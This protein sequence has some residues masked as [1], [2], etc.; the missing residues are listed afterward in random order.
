MLRVEAVNGGYGGVRVLSGVDLQVAAG[1]VLGVL[2]RN[3]AGK[4][5]LLKTI[6]GLLPA[7]GGQ[8]LI[9][10]A[11]ATRL[12]A[13]DIPRLGVGYVPQGRGLFRELSVAENL[14]MGLLV[15]DSGH[16][17]RERVLELFPVLRERLRQAAGTLSGGQQQM[18]AMGRALCL[19]PKVLLL[20][21]PS[22]GLQPSMVDRVLETV[23]LLRSQ[24]VAVVLVEQRVD[25]ALGVTDRVVFMENGRSVHTA[26]PAELRENPRPLHDYVGVRQR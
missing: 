14:Q 9:D 25:A 15:R 16:E 13:H 22:E 5:T 21:E 20:D 11:E 12:A 18:L 3:G 19:E 23:V 8:I 4:T 17:V 24:G 2:G 1:E 7:S 26:T 6:M 10:G